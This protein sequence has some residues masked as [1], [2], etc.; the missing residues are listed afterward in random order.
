MEKLMNRTY[1]YGK[2]VS[3]KE[4]ADFY[5]ALEK[6]QVQDCDIYIDSCSMDNR[7]CSQYTKLLKLLERGDLL[8]LGSLSVLGDG[9]TDVKEQW[10]ILT[11]EKQVDVMVLDVPSL[12]TRIGKDQYGLLVADLVYSLLDYVSAHDLRYSSEIRRLRQQAGITEARE[13][14]VKFGRPSKAMPENFGQICKRWM[15][16]GI[17]ATEAARMCGVSR[18]VFYK[19]VR[20]SGG[21]T[22]GDSK[23]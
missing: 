19:R 21:E 23:R 22:R 9:Y 8:C 10:R 11:K 16:K 3:E 13:K 4:K 5:A 1:A 6:L 18:A 12:D 7:K 17:T 20:E 14:G 2:A 15:E